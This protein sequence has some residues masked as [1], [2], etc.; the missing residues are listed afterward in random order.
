MT[1]DTLGTL[2]LFTMFKFSGS[3]TDIR[4]YLHLP[5]LRAEMIL[6]LIL[7]HGVLLGKSA[8]I[9]GL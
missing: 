9:S 3:I 4:E 5:E 8:D 7:I 2:N 1:S 6:I